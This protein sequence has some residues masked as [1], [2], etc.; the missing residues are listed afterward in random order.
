MLTRT[1]RLWA[2]MAV[3]GLQLAL[4]GCAQNVGDLDRTQPNR[5]DVS[6]LNDGKPWWFLQTVVGIPPASTFSFVGEASFPPDRIVWDVQENWLIAYRA[7]EWI[8]GSQTPYSATAHNNVIGGSN[9]PY[10]GTPVAAYAI[11]SHFDIQREYN[12]QTGEQ[13]NVISENTTDR[14]W[15]ERQ[16]VRVDWSNNALGSFNFMALGGTNLTGA[17][18]TSPLAYFPDQEDPTNPDRTEVSS[19]YIGVVNKISY[20]RAVRS[21]RSRS[22]SAIPSTPATSGRRPSAS[23][24]AA[25]AR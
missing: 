19:D 11:L 6:I 5:I 17:L 4:S 21:L 16:Y 22:T 20:T 2:L 9:S 12:P 24:I 18:L 15:Y 23:E 25:R 7:Y 13:T 1:S 10:F 8:V 14:P 3:A